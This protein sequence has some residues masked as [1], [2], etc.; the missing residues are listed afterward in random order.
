M[1]H[2]VFKVFEEEILAASIPFEDP[3]GNRWE[4]SW[5]DLTAEVVL[6]LSNS[7]RAAGCTTAMVVLPQSSNHIRLH[8]KPR[9]WPDQE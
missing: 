4:I 5:D 9:H 3:D 2:P 6:I 8:P 1:S 7:K